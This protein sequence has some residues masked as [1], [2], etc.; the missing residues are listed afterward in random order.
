MF[1]TPNKLKTYSPC[2]DGYVAFRKIYPEGAELVDIINNPQITEEFLHWG[3]ENLEISDEEFLAYQSRL[4]IIESSMFWKSSNIEHSRVVTNSSNITYSSFVHKSNYVDGSFTICNSQNI[5]NSSQIFSSKFVDNSK[6]VS[7]SATIMNSENIV[8]STSIIDSKS[9]IEGNDISF[10]SEIRKS[11]NI[12]DSHFCDSSENL[13]NCL[14]CFDLHDKEFCLFN[15]PIDER[16]YKMFLNQYQRFMNKQLDFVDEWPEETVRAI[17][18]TISLN[19]QKYYTLIDKN[20]WNWVSTLPN[21]DSKIM[22][23][24]TVLPQFLYH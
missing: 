6:K 3:R 1:L 22:Y 15:K 13:V 9:I 20:F 12:T 11:K 19:W 24:I 16:K 7:G 21:Y 18:P 8:N 14:F 4:G 5:N 17:E 23:S 10:S 2:K